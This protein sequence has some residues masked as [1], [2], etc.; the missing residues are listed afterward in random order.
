MT[1]RN[2]QQIQCIV[3]GGVV[4]ALCLWFVIPIF[5]AKVALGASWQAVAMAYMIW[6]G[7]LLSWGMLGTRTW[8]EA[9]GWPAIMALFF[10]IP[11]IPVIILVLK[12]FGRT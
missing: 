2:A 7:T 9:V 3:N 4:Y 6:F 11:A 12:A 8:G 1:R 5:L 10:T